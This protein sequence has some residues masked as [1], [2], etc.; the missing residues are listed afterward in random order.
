[1]SEEFAELVDEFMSSLPDSAR[2]DLVRERAG[3]LCLAVKRSYVGECSCE[4]CSEDAVDM[5]SLCSDCRFPE[6]SHDKPP[7]GCEWSLRYHIESGH[8][9]P[10]CEDPDIF[11]KAEAAYSEA[12]AWEHDPQKLSLVLY[13]AAGD[14]SNKDLA[15]G[16]G[17]TKQTVSAWRHGHAWPRQRRSRA[18]LIDFIK[19]RVE[20]IRDGSLRPG[21]WQFALTPLSRQR[22]AAGTYL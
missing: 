7:C 8:C 3:R 6:R 15:A 20:M 10:S 17:V 11:N 5:S 21:G 22:E 18:A 2:N 12:A 14:L 9:S 13:W 19:K 1:M 4:G 16:L